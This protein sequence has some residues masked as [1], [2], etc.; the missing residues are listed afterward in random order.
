MEN[1]V[2][3]KESCLQWSMS[4]RSVEEL[5]V[6]Y[7]PIVLYLLYLMSRKREESQ[8]NG[9]RRSKRDKESRGVAIPI[10]GTD[11]RLNTHR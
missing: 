11:K 7:L 5:V 4:C 1:R 9:G 10:P 2:E 8:I 6:S 3:N